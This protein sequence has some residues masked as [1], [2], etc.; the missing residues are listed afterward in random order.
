LAERRKLLEPIPRDA[1][2]ALV[3]EV[4][5][6]IPIVG[7]LF[8]AAEAFDALREGKTEA[9]V[10]YLLGILPGPPLP[11]THLVVYELYRRG[12]LRGVLG[13]AS[14]AS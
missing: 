1:V 12:G 8:M 2:E 13:E 3:R 14:K 6:F 7:D 11:L 10:A 5:S 4:V 9:G